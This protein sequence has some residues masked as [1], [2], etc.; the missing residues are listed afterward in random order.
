MHFLGMKMTPEIK[1][2]L[3][4]DSSGSFKK[5]KRGKSEVDLIYTTLS[6]EKI[7]SDL[8]TL[9]NNMKLAFDNKLKNYC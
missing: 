6:E 3:Q 4:K 8:T 2:C 1:T 5:K 9:F 7:G